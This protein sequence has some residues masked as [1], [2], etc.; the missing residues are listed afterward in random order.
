MKLGFVGLGNMGMPM[1]LNLLK[2]GHEIYGKNRSPAKEE[3]FVAAG[4]KAGLTLEEMAARMDAVITCL[5]MPAD[6]EA[7]YT[8]EGG[9]LAGARPG[10]LL[11]DCSTVSPELSRRLHERAASLG[12]ELLDAPV[13]GGTAGAAA[14]T[15]SVMA[16]G[17]QTAFEKARPLFEAIGK[18]IYYTGGPG[19]GSAVKLINQLMV[20]VHSQAAAEAF[21]LGASANL[22]AGMLFDILS[23]SFAQ[24]RIMDRHYT[25][26]IAKGDY[27]AGFA[28]KLLAKDM[29]LAADLG[30]SGGVDLAVGGR[31]RSL[32]ARAAA[33]GYG[34]E[35]M[36]VL[37]RAQ[38][39]GDERRNGQGGLRCFAVFLKMVDPDLSARYRER[40][41]QFLDERRQAGMLLANGRFADGAG[42]LV[43]YRTRSYEE[44]EHWVQ[45]DPYII[46]GAR[47][48]EIHEWDIVLADG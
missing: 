9:L 20:G 19:S 46:L 23:N 33:A 41:L 34:E 4:G 18:Q 29:N 36:S 26:Y 45:Q 10:A 48:Y 17:D 16:G 25:Q 31:A 35:D 32:I 27:T 6:V 39:E 2:A 28:L 30:E 40:H 1:A 21:A 3:A 11:I 24:S 43:V 47:S 13:S 44:T 15:L 42:G 8:G 37:H 7:V 22:E 12:A 14:A 38:R 5:P